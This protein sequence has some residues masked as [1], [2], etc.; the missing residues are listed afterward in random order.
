MVKTSAAGFSRRRFMAGSAALAAA[1][2]A[3]PEENRRLKVCVLG[4]SGTVGNAIMR[5]ILN[6]G[7][8]VIAIS[9]SSDKLAKIRGEYAAKG[10][11]TLVGDVASDESAAAL[12]AALHAQFGKP[13]GIVAAL[14]SP[15]ADRPMKVLGTPTD[16]LR[17]A[18]DTN[19]FTHVVAA[20]ALIPELGAGGVYVGVNGGL[21]DFVL[22]GM[23]N[24]TMTQSALRSL[25]LALAQE[26]DESKVQVRMLGLFGLVATEE[27]PAKNAERSIVDGDVGRRVLDI[28]LHPAAFPGP[29]LALK[30]R[31]YS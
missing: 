5:D 2:L 19:F 10:V 17:R 6:A 29:I 1:R 28:L 27:R 7:H 3:W 16:P 24:V 12:H 21:P 18:F 9:R 23:A 4:A 13:D 25:Y 30:A 11:Q 22:P 14:S 8:H 26:A 20:K 15:A 31:A